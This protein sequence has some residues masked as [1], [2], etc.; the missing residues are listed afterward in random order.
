MKCPKCKKQMVKSTYPNPNVVSYT[1]N[2][3]HEDVYVDGEKNPKNFNYEE[4]N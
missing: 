4:F 2:C 1:C 3:G